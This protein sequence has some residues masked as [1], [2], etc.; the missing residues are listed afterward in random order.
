MIKILLV[1]NGSGYQ[2]DKCLGFK[3]FKEAIA[4]IVSDRDCPALHVAEKHGIATHIFDKD[5]FALNKGICEYSEKNK[6]DY[7]ISPGFTRIFRG[8]ILTKFENRIFNCHPSILPGFKGFYDTRDV[9]RKHNARKIFERTLDF[10]SRVMGNTIHLINEHVD[11][12]SPVIV[13]HMNIPYDIEENYLR[14]LLFTQEVKCLLQVVVWLSENRI[15]VTN[16]G[17]VRVIG[18]TFDNNEFSPN[19]DDKVAKIMFDYPWSQEL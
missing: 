17:K 15:T 10:D 5:S 16:D 19:I 13:S 6:I 11:D 4:G 12:G 14:H 18:A 3:M 7:I 8:E 9:K 2:I 1:T